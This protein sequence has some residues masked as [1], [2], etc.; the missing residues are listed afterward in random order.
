MPELKVTLSVIVTALAVL[1]L[2]AALPSAIRDTIELELVNIFNGKK[3]V[4]EGLDA[5]VRRG[6]AILREFYVIN[7]AA[8]QG[9]I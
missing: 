6:N 4:S 3:T 5:A 8:P 7:C 9:E 1:I 2:V